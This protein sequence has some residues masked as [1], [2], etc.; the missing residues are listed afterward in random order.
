MKLQIREL[1]QIIESVNQYIEDNQSGE[2][3]DDIFQSRDAYD[4]AASSMESLAITTNSYLDSMGMM[5]GSNNS[6]GTFSPST[7]ISTPSSRRGAAAV[8]VMSLA[9]LP[10]SEFHQFRVKS[11]IAAVD[12]GFC[13]LG[14]GLQVLSSTLVT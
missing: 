3:S 9:D 12:D 4:L 14:H 6:I 13:R 1:E 7:S 11:S 2:I 10:V 5:M 8:P